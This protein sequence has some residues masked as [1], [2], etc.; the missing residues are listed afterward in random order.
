MGRTPQPDRSVFSQTAL[1]LAQEF[2]EPQLASIGLSVQQIESLSLED[3]E[4]AL[5]RVNEAIAHPDSFGTYR[6]AF[7]AEAGVL[8]AKANNDAHISIG[9]LP[10]L[11]ERK[12]MILRRIGLI[13]PQ[14]Q[15]TD[16]AAMVEG[17]VAD[18]A[19][20]ETLLK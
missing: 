20:R 8:L 19:A 6:L 10:I 4:A 7:T 9:I 3:C 18:P 12:S 14:E 13:R 11:L 1:D 16:I 17:T 5:E 15:L 2:F